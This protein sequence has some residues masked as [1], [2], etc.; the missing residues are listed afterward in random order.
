[1]TTNHYHQT[2]L[3]FEFNHKKLHGLE[4]FPVEAL[5]I[6]RREEIEKDISE[7]LENLLD[8]VANTVTSTTFNV[9]GLPLKD[10]LKKKDKDKKSEN[11]DDWQLFKD[12]V[13]SSMA[14]KAEYDLYARYLQLTYLL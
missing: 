6:Q 5:Q 8:N 4:G 13:K 12:F 1:M 2:I 14:D 9:D 11:D 7:I 10:W 3:G